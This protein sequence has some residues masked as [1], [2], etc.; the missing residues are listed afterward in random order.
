ME[1]TVGHQVLHVNEDA[2]RENPRMR[3]NS[4]F[5]SNWFNFSSRRNSGNNLPVSEAGVYPG[6]QHFNQ[7]HESL[8]LSENAFIY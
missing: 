7:V 4:R 6:A 1:E 3:R 8:H 2:G 5:W